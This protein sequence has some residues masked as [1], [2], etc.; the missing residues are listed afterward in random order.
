MSSNI[1]GSDNF[2]SADIGITTETNENGTAIKFPDGTLICYNDIILSRYDASALRGTWTYPVAFAAH[3]AV[4]TFTVLTIS[5][6]SNKP[7]TPVNTSRG[8]ASSELMLRTG[9]GSSYASGETLAVRA[10]AL[11]RWK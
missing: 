11:G 4:V 5:S 9:G 7:S 1:R 3:E 6:T 2:D 8:L 10:M